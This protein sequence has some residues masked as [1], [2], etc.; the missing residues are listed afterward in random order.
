VFK[1][2]SILFVLLCGFTV[3]SAAQ[4]GT[5]VRTN[6]TDLVVARYSLGAEAL[7]RPHLSV[8][9]DFDYIARNVFVGSDHLWYPGGDTKKRGIIL[10]PQVRWYPGAEGGRG[11]YTALSGFFGYARYY[12]LDGASWGV[13]PPEWMVG[14]GSLHVGHQF[15][16]G[17]FLL[18]GYL[19][20]TWTS[21]DDMGI[22][23]EDLLLFPQASGLRASGGLRL[24]IRTGGQR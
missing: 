15:T 8:G 23:Y 9:L 2:H 11:T 21:E 18:D 20:G 13:R 16:L 14:G 1:I 24:G 5:I 10:E 3:Q 7:V 12:R 17:R 22:Y 4:E 19:G 6:L